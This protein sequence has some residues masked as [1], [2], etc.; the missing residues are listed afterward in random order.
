MSHRNTALIERSRG[1][2]SV[3]LSDGGGTNGGEVGPYRAIWALLFKF[4]M[5]LHLLDSER[6]LKDT[7]AVAQTGST[8]TPHRWPVK[9][10]FGLLV[11]AEHNSSTPSKAVFSGECFR[12]RRTL[13]SYW[14]HVCVRPMNVIWCIFIEK[15]WSGQLSLPFVEPDRF[16]FL[17]SF[18]HENCAL[19]CQTGNLV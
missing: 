12:Q 1:S 15:Y 10:Y 4:T 3:H 14:S 6:T 18:C 16:F 17:L 7:S 13:S 9:A 5:H 19:Q 8:F 11:A 2:G